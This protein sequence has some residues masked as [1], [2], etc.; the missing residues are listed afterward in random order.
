MQFERVLLTGAGGMLGSAIWP[1]SCSRFS[2]VVATDR[3]CTEP[4]LRPLDV[5]DRRA[6]S[7]RF[8]DH[9]P[10]LVLH[11]AAETDLEFCEA[12]PR[13][14]HEVNCEGAAIV[15]E[16]CARHG[17]TMVYISTAGVFD[18]EKVEPYTEDDPARPIMVYGRTKLDGERA[19]AALCPR[20]YVVRAGWMIGGGGRKDK[21][22]VQKILG[23]VM[24]GQRVVRAVNDKWGTPT[25]TR[26]FAN[27]LFRLLE[28][29]E[30]GLYHMVCEG[31]GTRYDVARE[32]LDICGRSDVEVVPVDSSAFAGDYFAPRPRSE[33]MTNARLTRMGINLMSNWR[34]AL[35]E[36][37]ALEFPL[38]RMGMIPEGAGNAVPERRAKAADRRT[39]ELSWNTQERR[40]LASRRRQ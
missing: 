13:M 3:D 29:R 18:G 24:S 39:R 38:A 9:R 19:T 35:R 32:L 26:Q 12:H 22:F 34:Q 20:H 30:Y 37:M 4:W 31:A 8:D 23:Q 36:Y 40:K 10:Q 5:T 27:N 2:E 1:L 7:Q 28:T 21:K 11:L 25:Y 16:Q 6:V 14:A 33:M 17:A 15:A